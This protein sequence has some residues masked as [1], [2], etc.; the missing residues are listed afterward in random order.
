M[1]IYL[2]CEFNGFN[3]QLLSIAL[4]PETG[5]YLYR[6][7]VVTEPLDP[8]VAK[9]VMPL[10]DTSSEA[11]E[12]VTPAQLAIDLQG[13][14]ART[15]SYRLN[16][17]ADWPDDIAYLC[18]AMMTG[19]GEMISTPEISFELRRDLSCDKAERRH[20]ALSDAF[21]LRD[22]HLRKRDYVR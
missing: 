1:N 17:I 16:I 12:Y 22:D 19:P 20:N 3:G 11:R 8:W 6:E 7:L 4:V 13:W 10:M 2:D 18:K 5:P 9:N 15:G 21:A 14:L